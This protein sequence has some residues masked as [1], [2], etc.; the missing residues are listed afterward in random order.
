MTTRILIADDHEM[1][2]AGIRAVLAGREGW[3]IVAEAGDGRDAIAKALQTRPHVAV[4]DYFLP[5]IDGVEVTRQIRD[6]LP[7]TE[8]LIFTLHD[9][10]AVM[11]EVLNA[12]ARAFVLKSEAN[13]LLVSA[14]A[15]LEHHRPFF[16]RKLSERLVQGYLAKG[17]RTPLDLLTPRERTI[18]QLITEGNT[19]Q[20]IAS[21][22]NLSVKTIESHRAGAMAKIGATS[23]AGIVRY[24]IKHKLVKP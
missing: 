16:S 1:V 9:D 11:S 21:L 20:Q 12:G 22:L 18:V 6:R 3:E 23:T 4:V 8:V 2:R 15:A 24:A 19:N 7:G 14:V 17:S 5:I 10:D 13:E